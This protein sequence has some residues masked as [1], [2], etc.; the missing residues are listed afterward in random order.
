MP[1][2]IVSMSGFVLFM[3]SNLRA[4]TRNTSLSLSLSRLNQSQ[5]ETSVSLQAFL[6]YQLE[7][8]SV[9][10]CLSWFRHGRLYVCLHHI[11]HTDKDLR[12]SKEFPILEL[13]SP[14]VQTRKS[15]LL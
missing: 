9:E 2:D 15:Q 3:S 5:I 13:V 7:I 1:T 10:R 4:C 11:Y 12:T 8:I 14:V 6:N